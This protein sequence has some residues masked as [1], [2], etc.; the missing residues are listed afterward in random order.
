MLLGTASMKEFV[1]HELYTQTMGSRN[2]QPSVLGIHQ[3]SRSKSTRD[4]M[5]PL[6]R[7]NSCF[8]INF[9]KN[10]VVVV[11]VRSY[12]FKYS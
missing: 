9:L 2:D 12:R 11:V 5:Q 7:N 8:T 10:V 6:G 4:I 3:E 1:S